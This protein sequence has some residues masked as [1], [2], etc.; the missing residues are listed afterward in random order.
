M[1]LPGANAVGA[2][3]HV[4]EAAHAMPR[5]VIVVQPQPLPSPGDREAMAKPLVTP[6]FRSIGSSR[7]R[8]QAAVLGTGV[9]GGSTGACL[10]QRHPR[11]CV[12][13]DPC[14]RVRSRANGKMCGRSHCL[15]LLRSTTNLN[16]SPW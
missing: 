5:A 9:L 16:D 8:P 12:Q 6:E 4:Q 14:R 3:V 11:K 7:H 13:L 1:S 2:L 10:P 15:Q